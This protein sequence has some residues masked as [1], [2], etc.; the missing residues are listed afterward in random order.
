MT[1]WLCRV[2]PDELD[3]LLGQ[4]AQA[5]SLGIDGWVL[6]LQQDTALEIKH[7]LQDWPLEM[8]L[9][10]ELTGLLFD[11]DLLDQALTHPCATRF[12][13]KPLL[14]TQSELH[15]PEL[16]LTTT[17]LFSLDPSDECVGVAGSIPTADA[18]YLLN[19][20]WFLK[21][22]HFRGSKPYIFI[23]AV[24]A[25]IANEDKLFKAADSVR[26]R[27]WL[28]LESAWCIM[29]VGEADATV[30][31]ESWQGHQRW[32]LPTQRVPSGK[33]DFVPAI[34]EGTSSRGWGVMQPKHLAV[35]IHGYYLDQLQ[36]LLKLLPPGGE[37]CDWPGIDL[38]ITTPCHQLLEAAA[39]VKSLSWPR[40][41]LFGV[42]NRGRDVA[43][44]LLHALPVIVDM[45]HR[46]V[47]K[48]HTKSS[49]HMDFG[50]AWGQYLIEQLLQP[51]VLEGFSSS[52][53]L[54]LLGP[55][56]ML[57]PMSLNLA[58]NAAHLDQLK[59]LS[60]LY[61][62]DLLD[63]QFIAGTMFAARVEAL[64]PLCSLG[65]LLDDFEH[66]WGQVDGTLSHA[67]ER[68]FAVVARTNGFSVKELSGNNSLIPD[69]G[70]ASASLFEPKASLKSQVDNNI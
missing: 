68:W 8:Q 22:A 1:R 11:V 66:E 14:F 67:L 5:R 6:P 65:L 37:R 63:L 41:R 30:L 7:L 55:P 9:T 25:L 4:T 45:G 38:Y 69:F 20:E 53:E 52:S 10:L 59:Q 58:D 61:D 57:L 2:Q 13:G 28:D 60:G 24:R 50:D 15:P 46:F 48:L 49:P 33:Y 32:Y 56:G 64:S 16:I 35:V 12:R 47:L 54:G 18:Q 23:P 39:M 27:A 34:E 19:Y 51:E 70:F 29:Q 62:C 36:D 40:V 17:A 3:G 21:Q 31:I 42:Q 26:Y 44:F 43:P